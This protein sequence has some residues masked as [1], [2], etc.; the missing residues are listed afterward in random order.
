MGSSLFEEHKF[1]KFSSLMLFRFVIVGTHFEIPS[2]F[3]QVPFAAHGY[4]SFFA[5][6][7]M[8]RYYKPSE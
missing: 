8:D 6:S 2:S 7:V 5:L 4:G 3:V 1:V